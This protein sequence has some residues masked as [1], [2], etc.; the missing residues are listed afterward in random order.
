MK[1]T[2]K[3]I[4]IVVCA[5]VVLLSAI[6]IFGGDSDTSTSNAETQKAETITTTTATTNNKVGNY[7]VEIVNCEIAKDGEGKDVAIITYNFTNNSEEAASFAYAIND[8]VYQ[9]GVEAERSYWYDVVENEEDNGTKEIKTGTTLKV[10]QAYYLNN[11][12]SPIEVEITELFGFTDEK[13]VKV[14]ELAKE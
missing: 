1:K 2:G 8:V 10:V 14:F 9:D 4:L 3:I 5:I 7:I 13:V 6:I 12:T 11:V